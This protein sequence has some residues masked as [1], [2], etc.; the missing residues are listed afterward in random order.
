MSP[1]SL[2]NLAVLYNQGRYA[3]AEPLYKR[4]L[5]IG[6]R[7]WARIIP[8]RRSLNNLAILN[9]QGKYAEAEPLYKRSLAIRRRPWAR[10]IRRRHK[11]EQPGW[12]LPPR[13]V[14]R[15]RATA[16]AVAGNHEKALGSDHP[17]VA[18]SLN[19]L[20]ELYRYQGRYAEAEPLYK[21]S[22]AIREK[23]LGPDHP[24][25]AISLNNLASLY[26]LNRASTPRPNR[27]TS[28]R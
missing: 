16:Q 20:A 1:T 12:P 10:T 13:Q 8:S 28:G 9:N 21:R 4:S 6:R 17:D 24:D 7:P 27:S 11:P 14:R 26:D 23:A 3:E 15:G 25:V 5:A 2:N 19:N 18:K 22:L